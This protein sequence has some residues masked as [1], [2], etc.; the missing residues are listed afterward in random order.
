ME[1]LPAIRVYRLL[2]LAIRVM[3]LQVAFP[4]IGLGAPFDLYGHG[5]MDIREL[6]KSI[7]TFV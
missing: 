5:H 4:K 1:R 3:L 2:Q 6:S 7:L